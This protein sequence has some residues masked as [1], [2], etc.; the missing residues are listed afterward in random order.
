VRRL[1]GVAPALQ[2]LIGSA[3]IDRTEALE[4]SMKKTYEKPTL[5]RRIKLPAVTA[6]VTASEELPQLPQTPE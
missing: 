2:R 6:M 1:L 3:A 5:L 4:I